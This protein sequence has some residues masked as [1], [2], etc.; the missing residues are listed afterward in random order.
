MLNEQNRES[1]RERQKA[2]R[3]KT[4]LETAE[5]LF[6]QKGYVATTIAEIANNAE[7]SA[8]TVH[9]YFGSKGAILVALID[10]YDS[11]FIERH[12]HDLEAISESPRNDIVK[13]LEAIVQDAL[14]RLPAEA[15]VHALSNSILEAGGE[16]EEGYVELNNRLY[17]LLYVPLKAHR[18]AGN[19][20]ADF[21]VDA[22]REMFELINHALFEQ[23]IGTSPFDMDDYRKR[24]CSYVGFVVNT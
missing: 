5:Q 18:Q 16:I 7:V 10:Q 15:W 13:L 14:D 1:L 17:D 9:N 22:A 2:K 21:D 19:L 20:G 11:E 23:R 4:L 24:L 12:E 6:H 8:G 3:Y